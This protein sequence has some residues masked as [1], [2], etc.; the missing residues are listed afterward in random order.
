[1][2]EPPSTTEAAVSSHEVS[3]PSTRWA[4]P[5]PGPVPV[6]VPVFV[7]IPRDTRSPGQGQDGRARDRPVARPPHAGGTIPE[8]DQW[9][10]V[11]A[12]S[13][14]SDAPMPARRSAY[15]SESMS[16]THMT[17]ASSP[18]TG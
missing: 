14:G 10:E 1:M 15:A 18:V 5:V 8:P 6:S 13:A 16:R 7:S 11:T 17:R 4:A 2:V 3:M 12:R 9:R